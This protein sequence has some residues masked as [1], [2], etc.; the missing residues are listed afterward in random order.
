MNQDETFAPGDLVWLTALGPAVCT[1][2]NYLPGQ[3]N[4]VTG[5]G[6]RYTVRPG[7]IT[8]RLTA[9][10]VRGQADYMD[11]CGRPAAAQAARALLDD[12]AQYVAAAAAAQEDQHGY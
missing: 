12:A 7:N 9:E 11:T 2:P 1:G 4:F 3:Y 8:G 5:Y 10:Q 6:T